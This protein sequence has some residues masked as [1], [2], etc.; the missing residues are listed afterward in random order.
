[1]GLFSIANLHFNYVPTRTL[2]GL[3]TGMILH[4]P[5]PSSSVQSQSCLLEF[6]ETTYSCLV[7]H[8]VEYRSV[9]ATTTELN[10]I[11]NLLRELDLS[12]T[13]APVIYCD[14]VGATNLCSNPVFHSRMKH[15]ALDYHF[16]D[17]PNSQGTFLY[18]FFNSDPNSAQHSAWFKRLYR[19]HGVPTLRAVALVVCA[20][21]R[22]RSRCCA[23]SHTL[24]RVVAYT[25]VRCHVRCCALSNTLL[26]TI[27]RTGTLSCALGTLSI[28]TLPSQPSLVAALEGYVAI[29][30]DR[31]YRDK[32]FFVATGLLMFFVATK[33]SMSR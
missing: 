9:A 12:S 11:S 22:S 28:A 18:F 2:I 27:A 10:W 13:Q 32:K 26:S 16:Y 5:A 20:V 8:D 6:Y 29:P 3:A 25:V 4:P 23:L 24:L 31:P 1:M 21:T 14:N 19:V 33:N 30:N 15:V 7:L 17:A